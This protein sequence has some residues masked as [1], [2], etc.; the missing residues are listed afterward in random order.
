MQT[1]FCVD[2]ASNKDQVIKDKLIEGHKEKIDSRIYNTCKVEK[3]QD[4]ESK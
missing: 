3:W 4:K 2:C 1:F